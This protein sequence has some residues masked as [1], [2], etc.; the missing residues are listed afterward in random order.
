[1][2]KITFKKNINAPKEKV[3]DV[4]LGDKTYRVWA[5]EFMPGSYADTDWKEG[6]KALFLSSDGNGMVSR[7]E[8][9]IPNEYISIHHLGMVKDGIE[10]LT[11]DKVKQWAG[12]HE[13]YTLKENDGVTEV[14]VDM[15]TDIEYKDYFLTT[16]PKALDKVKELSEAK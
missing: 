11:S 10:D 12:A 9:N 14:T 8:R 3:W 13:N 2:E 7:I 16:W 15:D 1:M 4:L 5:S 6:S